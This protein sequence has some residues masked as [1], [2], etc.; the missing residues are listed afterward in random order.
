[1]ALETVGGTS[2]QDG[3]SRLTTEYIYWKI[4]SD[5]NFSS[6]DAYVA[7]KE[8]SGDK[9]SEQDWEAAEILEHP[10]DP[11]NDAIRVLVGADGGVDLTPETASPQTYRVWLRIDTLEENIVRSAGTLKVR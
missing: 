10:D 6:A 9:P 11:E 4:V 8:E 3:I 7:F 2:P 5:E 1:M